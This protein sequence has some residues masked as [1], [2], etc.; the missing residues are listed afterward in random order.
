[1]PAGTVTEAGEKPV[2]VI[3]IR[4][5]ATAGLGLLVNGVGLPEIDGLVLG[6]VCKNRLGS[7]WDVSCKAGV[8]VGVGASAG[9]VE[10]QIIKPITT[11]TITAINI[12]TAAFVIRSSIRYAYGASS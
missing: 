1:M 6:A 12:P 10:R 7:V 11:T 8:G 4:V 9:A 2:S 3:E 5:A